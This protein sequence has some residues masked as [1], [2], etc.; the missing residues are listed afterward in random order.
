MTPHEEPQPETTVTKILVGAL[1]FLGAAGI[2][3]SI[4]MYGQMT[5]M[6]E[7]LTSVISTVSDLSRRVQECEEHTRATKQGTKL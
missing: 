5:G 1:T 6:Q 2:I 3:G 7:R 4:G